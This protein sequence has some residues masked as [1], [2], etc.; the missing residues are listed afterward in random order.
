MKPEQK[1][2]RRAVKTARKAAKEKEQ[3]ERLRIVREF[4]PGIDGLL[5]DIQ[6]R[7]E[8]EPTPPKKTTREDVNQAAARIVRKATKK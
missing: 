2:K 3:V 6:M 8:V 4:E 7:N 5:E 1:A